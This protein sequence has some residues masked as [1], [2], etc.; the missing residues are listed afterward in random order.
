MDDPLRFLTP[1][2]L[3]DRPFPP[4]LGFAEM[5]GWREFGRG[6]PAPRTLDQPRDK[7]VHRPRPSLPPEI[8]QRP[9]PQKHPPATIPPR[10]Q[11]LPWLP[12][13][14]G[15]WL[16]THPQAFADA[17]STNRGAV[18]SHQRQPK[19]PWSIHV[20]RVPRNPPT[21]QIRSTHAGS[22]AI[23]MDLLSA[24]V[25]Q[26]HTQAGQPI[27]AVNGDFYQRSQAHA[28]DPRGLQIVDG[29]LL[30]A[31]SGGVAF[32]IDS[33]AQ[34]HIGYVL[35][36]LR[37]TW[38]DGN[39][40]FQAPFDVNGD[41]DSDELQLYTPSVGPRTRTSGGRE[42]ILE[43]TNSTP[44]GPLQIGRTYAAK[45]REMRTTG[46]SPVAAGT[47]VLS[48]GPA[49][50]KKLSSLKAG[51]VLEI[52]TATV[53]DLAGAQQAI[54]GGPT[55]VRRG[56]RMKIVPPQVDS[57][58]ATSMLERHPRTA[59]GWNA[60]E[61]ILAVVDGR[62][63]NLSVGMTLEELGDTMFKLGCTDAM[64]LDGGGS[65]TLWYDGRVRNSPCDGRERPI[66]N[67]LVVTSP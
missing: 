41:R 30:S 19:V 66:A 16:G 20:V 32:W 23:G 27:A 51:M 45:V 64:N 7:S 37:V 43:P 61:F 54:G 57:Y 22:A 26:L 13:F 28:G 36:Q 4:I 67:A 33:Q 34:P 63:K 48:A 5:T 65:A 39:G 15:L 49:A 12:L 56:R 25:R 14:V 50:A 62:Q 6:M 52:S 46:D 17:A 29:E 47:W 8:P 38:P 1:K 10:S 18:Y 3:Q 42:W 60:Q 9:Q 59:I 2:T 44:W 21:F 55:L 11:R 58:E 35:S 53:P 40:A 31:P 24:Q